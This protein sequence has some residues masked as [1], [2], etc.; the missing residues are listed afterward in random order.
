VFRPPV[1]L[2]AVGSYAAGAAARPSPVVDLALE[3][4]RSCFD[5]KDQ[6]NHRYHAKRALYLA[7]AAAALRSAAA[8]LGLA[9]VEWAAVN[10][11]PRRPALLL[12]LQAGASPA[13]AALRLLPAL[14]AGTFPLQRLAPGRNNL[15][16]AVLPAAATGGE[17]QQAPTPHY[18]NSILQ[19]MMAA[20]HAAAVKA[21][22]ARVP[23]FA[24]AAVLLRVWARNQQLD[25]GADGL[26]GFLLT[27]L[28]AHLVQKGVATPGMNAMHLFRTAVLALSNRKT[29]SGSG[30][31]M[32]RASPP[33]PATGDPPTAKAWRAAGDEVVFVDPSG[34]LNLGASVSAAALRQAQA[35]ATRTAA[36]LSASAGPES[37][38]AVF[39]A[40]HSLAT[41]YDSW[42]RV[43]VPP[44]PQGALALAADAPQWRAT[45]R[46]VAAL[47]ARALGT[48]AALVRVVGRGCG[49]PASLKKGA[50]GA[51]R[52]HALL[53]VRLDSGG[54]A[55]R[56]VDMGP[57]ADSG[58]P[59][60]E[61]RDF[62]GERSELRR[63]QDGSIAEAV[64][65]EAGPAGRH[66]IADQAVAHALRRHLPPGAAVAGG[67]GALDAALLRRHSTPDA[68]AAA[69]R[70]VE[71]AADRLGKRLRGLQG[72][73]LRVV[74]TQAL[75]PALRRAAAFPPLPHPLAGA[76]ADALA[77]DH[78]A[79]C[80]PAVPLLCQLEGSGRWPDDVAAYAKAKAAVGV[81]L[82][83][84]LRG[85]FGMDV[86]AAEGYVDVLTDGFAFRLVL[87]GER[88][89]AMQHKALAA[90]GLAAP[91]PEADLAL[92]LWHQGAVSAAAAANAAFEPAVR[93][94]KRWV[95]AHL[96]SPHL[97]EEA[98]EL[99]VA[100]AFASGA[101]AA[102]PPPASRLAG[103]LRFLRLL[104]GHPWAVAPLVAD[105]GG[106]EPP[107]AR[108][109]AAARAHAAARARGAAPAM[110]LAGPADDACV[111]WTRDRPSRPLLHR[112]VV[113]ARRS[114]AAL[115]AFLCGA[116]GGDGDDDGDGGGGGAA[117]LAAVF[118]REEGEY[119][120]LIRLRRDALPNGDCDLRVDASAAGTGGG[121]RG[122]A[123][124]RKEL[125][126]GFDP[127]PLYIDLLEQ[128]L[129][130]VAVFCAD[131]VG[132]AVVGVKWRR[133]AFAPAPLRP[134]TAHAMAPAARGPPLE[135]APDVEAILADAAALGAGLVES[136]EVAEDDV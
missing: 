40:R 95:G 125:L 77:S 5:D 59:A 122:S 74:A 18:N 64:V 21:A 28:L 49:A 82:A 135:G 67:A 63:F 99:L 127:V 126:V 112:A 87:A 4:P 29:F 109:E 39:L 133:A 90:A 38:D 80:L 20:R 128:R 62:W 119:D 124:V 27:M 131:Y 97:R 108:R 51:A 81:E 102:A 7:H 11:D 105:P 17:A 103:L 58:A 56:S 71:G 107:A 8:P 26:G 30:L 116:D 76:P 98:V 129:G 2:E 15:R 37:F 54:A 25:A 93:L 55:L 47:A 88:D 41:L 24:E 89:G 78:V 52:A 94:A 9:R 85:G 14:A 118:G 96:L 61:F 68:D 70:A 31:V 121:G 46:R 120:A 3:M 16:S 136:V 101:G 23:R 132:G 1:S 69:Q 86:A 44:P 79:R 12:H 113:L 114:A 43:T 117:L 50:P 73:T 57:A 22:A 91:P 48:R 110:F 13:G 115:E 75:A 72:L 92:R 34:W 19:D 53:G 36:L 66:L 104:G 123:A 65:W 84:A 134:E 60:R 42:Y 45:D 100:A 111:G 10:G 106:G 6:L 35:A 33:L 130:S 83:Q 32:A